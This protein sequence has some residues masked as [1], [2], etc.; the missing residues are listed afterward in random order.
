M[1]HTPG[2]APPPPDGHPTAPAGSAGSAGGSGP[3]GPAAS[4]GPAGPSGPAAPAGPS[5]SDHA[6]ALGHGPAIAGAEGRGW[7]RRMWPYL[8]R[9]GRDLVLVFG[10]ALLG[11]GIT[12]VLPLLTRSVV[13]DALKPVVAGQAAESLAPLLTAMLALGAVRFG[14][15]FVRRFGAGRLGIDVEYDMRNDIYDHLHRLDFA[16]HDEM[17]SG[18][19]VSRANS[20]VRVV[21]LLLGFLPF[22]SANIVLFFLSLGLM[23]H[24]SPQLTAVALVSVPSLLVMALRLRTVVYPSSWDAQ[25]RAAELATVVDEATTGVRVVKGFGQE[26]RELEKLTESAERLFG[27]R[28]RN[29]RI[30]AKRQAIMETVPSLAQVAVLALGGWLVI[31][32][33]ITLGTL[34]AFQTYLLQLVAPVRQVAGMLVVA[35]TARAAAERIFELLDSTSDVVER[36]D[37]RPL[38]DIR[39]EVVFDDVSFGYLRSEPVLDHLSLR[40]A[41]GEVVA[42]VGA[43]GSGKSTVSL[44]LPRFYDVQ[45][46]AITVDG[47]D[48]RDVRLESL[49]RH[50]GVVFEESFLFSDTI[51]ANLSYGRPDASEEEIVRA[52]RWAQADGFIRALPEGYDTVVGERGLTLSGGQRQRIAL[53]RALLTDPQVLL[54]DDATSAIDVRTEEEIH[55][56]LRQVMKG[57]TTIL[58]AHRRSTLN[59]ADRI[60]VLDHGRLVDAGTHDEL[61]ARCRLYRLL[62]GGVD[63]DIDTIAEDA[64]VAAAAP[65]PA[66]GGPGA[67]RETAASGNGAAGDGAPGNGREAGTPA[68][69]AVGSGHGSGAPGDGGGAG[70]PA[71]GS[72]NAAPAGGLVASGA[73]ASGA[74]AS[75]APAGGAPAS[76]PPASGPPADGAS[77]GGVPAGV[78]ASAWRRSSDTDAE[79]AETQRQSYLAARAAGA[80]GAGGMGMARMGMGGGMGVAVRMNQPPTPELLAQIEALPPIVD[81]PETDVAEAATPAPD[82]TFGRVLRPQRRRMGV[83][84]FLV[85]VDAITTLAGPYLVNIGVQRGVR[86][87]DVGWLMAAAGMFLI[88][89]VVSSIIEYFDTVVSSKLGQELLLSLRIRVFAHLQRLGLDY[90]DREMTGRILTRMTSDLEAMQSLLQSGFVDAMIQLV[91]FVGAIVILV[92]MNAQLSLVV[93]SVVPPLVISTVVFRRRSARAYGEVRDR[94]AAVNAN[95]AESVSGMRVAQ[96]F[97]REQRNMEGFRVVARQHRS[98]RIDSTFIASMYFPFVEL[99]SSVATVLVLWV[100]SGL[101]RDGQLG[102]GPLFAFVLYLTAVFAPIQQ[103]S[104]VF[105]TYQQGNVAMD[106][107]KELMAV[108]VSVRE[109]AH[110]IAPGRLAGR[111]RFEDVSF[112]YA[113]TPE[114]ALRHVSLAV[115]PGETV[116]FVG[117][118]GAGKSTLVKLAARLYD[119]TDGDVL[120]DNVPLTEVDLEAFRRQLGY[121]PQEAFLFT[122]TVRDN[123]AYARPDATDA[124]VEAAA[125]AVGAHDFIAR[126]PSGYLQPVVERGRSLSSGQRQLIALARAQL[127][128]PA[129]LI[130]DEATANL[131]LATEAEVVRAMGRVSQGRTTL[132]IA[133]RLQSAARADRIVMLDH[134]QVAE[135]GRHAELIADGGA[136][137]DLWTS[138]LGGA[139]ETSE[140]PKDAEKASNAAER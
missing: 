57:R 34:L 31:Q 53:A 88:V 135:V 100:G 118:T 13:D 46:G 41:P 127:V 111:L 42:L 49:R 29:A 9:H 63:D 98:A 139:G 107:I 126:L 2:A 78:T 101:V 77:G 130:L 33:N 27:A 21:Q 43:S 32:G 17:Q 103:L 60:V 51:R 22:M 85:G 92:H 16:R 132:L 19:L 58:V 25:Q 112:T 64:A 74:P 71:S 3:S 66:N 45:A 84:A 6:P 90:Y 95:L 44:M 96:A 69:G 113:N 117:E 82:L 68:S 50:L 23:V 62:V 86:G 109:S 18:Q 15:S 72:G 136:Y 61:M 114:P 124:E 10:A 37:A 105:D 104:Q 140:T 120:V 26:R 12:A 40:V 128:D 47:H 30:S 54:L 131:D 1:S 24:L 110:P 39:G 94:I 125:R 4:G 99:L 133:H 89:A 36:P 129:I 108:P 106:R 70:T 20:D 93:L 102:I 55:D 123:I 134:G 76:G 83:A 65:P 79:L 11:T 115:D 119:P 35:S 52:A 56:T 138:Y 14:L 137:A 59:L 7:L 80:A 97:A 122:G 91:T 5:A 121:V 48:V 8:R 38:G 81:S 67:G 28:M 73:S 87:D 116:A 75:G